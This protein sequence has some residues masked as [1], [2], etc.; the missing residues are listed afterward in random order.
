MM[1]GEFPST[2]LGMNQNG[3]NTP[4]PRVFRKSGKQRACGIRNLEESTQNRKLVF[5]GLRSVNHGMAD[6]IPT[7]GCFAQRVRNRLKRKGMTF[8]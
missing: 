2:A 1:G 6:V 5:R 3:K 7:P 8:V 4:T